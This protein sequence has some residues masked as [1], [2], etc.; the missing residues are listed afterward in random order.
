MRNTFDLK[1]VIEIY[2]LPRVTGIGTAPICPVMGTLKH[3]VPWETSADN[4]AELGFV[5]NSSFADHV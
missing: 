5:L 4:V 1:S 3:K 2:E